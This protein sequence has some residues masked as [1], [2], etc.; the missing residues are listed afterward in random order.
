LFCKAEDHM[1]ASSFIPQSAREAGVPA[2][3]RYWTGRSGRRYLFTRTDA[4]SLEDFR[5]AVLLAVRFGDIV[6]A[7]DSAAEARRHAA[8]RGTGV[9]VHLLA[10]SAAAR[11]E[12]A[13]DLAPEPAPQAELAA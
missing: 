11:R 6:W 5:G 12:I 13:A 3:Y 1:A 4:G 9:Y 8:S 2:R 7:G 10:A